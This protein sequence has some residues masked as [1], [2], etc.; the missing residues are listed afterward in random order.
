MYHAAVVSHRRGRHLSSVGAKRL[1]RDAASNLL[2]C[3]S[4]RPPSWVEDRPGAGVPGRRPPS[5]AAHS[6]FRDQISWQLGQKWM[7]PPRNDCLTR[8]VA[9]FGHGLPTLRWLIT[10]G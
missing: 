5:E 3:A 1:D 2:C 10:V 8:A 9:H 7:L 6:S 4:T